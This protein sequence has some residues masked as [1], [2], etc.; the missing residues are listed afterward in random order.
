MKEKQ[1]P[2]L[3]KIEMSDILRA[4]GDSTRL[5]IARTLY[6]ADQPLTCQQA[7]SD[8]KN[9]PVSSRSHCFHVLREGGV[10]LSE[11]QGRECLNTIRSDE[12]EKKFP[13][14]LKTILGS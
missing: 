10:I 5:H 7:V 1:H 13:G 6:G 2:P 14:L 3:S 8:I 11:I 9:L 12:L 4:L